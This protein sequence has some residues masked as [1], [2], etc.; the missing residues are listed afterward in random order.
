MAH[1]YVPQ[2]Q[3]QGVCRRFVPDIQVC[4]THG[5]EDLVNATI[6][7]NA[8][9]EE[10]LLMSHTTEII[11]P[12]TA[13][14]AQ[15]KLLWLQKLCRTLQLAF[16]VLNVWGCQTYARIYMCIECRRGG[17][18]VCVCV[19][20]DGCGCIW[21]CAWYVS[22]VCVL[23][24]V[25]MYVVWWVCVCVR[26]CLCVWVGMIGMCWTC[27]STF[28][29]SCMRLLVCMF[30]YAPIHA[31]PRELYVLICVTMI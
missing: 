10:E 16:H 14:N 19:W 2:N 8:E 25:C 27:A 15:P 9:E 17:G 20:G 26:V 6:T 7:S 12:W 28:N 3:A 30:T 29:N 1:L 11:L 21:L 5:R 4:G 13:P 23:V 18:G 24:W 31:Y 22:D